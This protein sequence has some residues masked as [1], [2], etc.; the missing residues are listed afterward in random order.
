MQPPRALL[1]TS[2]LIALAHPAFGQVNDEKYQD[3]FLVGE[4]GEV[5][6]MCE[7]IILCENT[8]TVPSHELIPA[9]VDFTL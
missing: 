9:E 1:F 5:C 7:V 3:L 6:T 2:L 8:D 4:F